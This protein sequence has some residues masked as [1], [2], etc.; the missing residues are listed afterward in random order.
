MSRQFQLD[1]AIQSLIDV[2]DQAESEEQRHQAIE[3]LSR[4]DSTDAVRTLMDAYRSS[5]W[6][7]TKIQIL[8]SM[9][10][11]KNQRA[12]EFL[13]DVADRTEDLPMAS[14]ALLALGEQ[15]S[16]LSAIYLYQVLRD[17]RHPLQKE[18]VIAL[19]KIP[20]FDCDDAL[21]NCLRCAQNFAPTTLQ[22]VI[23][24]CARRRI[25]G[26]LELI[27]SI[28]SSS[29]WESSGPVFNAVIIAVGQLG[30]RADVEFLRALNTRYRFFADQLVQ[31]SIQQLED[32]AGLSIEDSVTLMLAADVPE[33][34]NDYVVSLRLHRLDQILQV[35]K[36]LGS[37]MSSNVLL[38]V[39]ATHMADPAARRIILDQIEVI[40]T[41]TEDLAL[42]LWNFE[43]KASQQEIDQLIAVAASKDWYCDLLKLV[44]VKG[45]HS[46]LIES[47][48]DEKRTPAA[49]IS[50]CN[51]LVSQARLSGEADRNQIAGQMM[52]A[53]R[54]ISHPQVKH[55][56]I[57][58]I[59]QI[60]PTVPSLV[61]DL[62]GFLKDDPEAFG[63]V[64]YSL[65]ALN[66]ADAVKAISKRL[67]QLVADGR[68]GA[69][70]SACLRSLSESNQHC[71]DLSLPLVKSD[72][73]RLHARGW[74]RI[75]TRYRL[76]GFE[77]LIKDALESTHIQMRLMG[78][79]AASTN[80]SV[81][82]IDEIFP[83]TGHSSRVLAGRALHTICVGGTPAQQTRVLNQELGA[84]DF[85][86]TRVQR[87]LRMLNV[88]SEQDYS[89]MRHVLDGWLQNQDASQSRDLVAAV[90]NFRDNLQMQGISAEVKA[91]S[92]TKIPDRHEIDARLIA[93]LSRFGEVSETIKSVL[94]NAELTFSHPELFDDR[95]DKSTMIVEF[96]KS[97]DLYLQEKLGPPIFLN[98]S[99]EAFTR[100]QSR[101][102]HLQL[103][104]ESI[105]VAKRIKDLQIVGHFDIDNFPSHKLVGIGR[106]IGS[107][108]ILRDQ[109]K[110]IDGL[111]AWALI[112]L[113]F[114]R[115]FNYQGQ[116]LPA[117]LPVKDSRNRN[118]GE[119]ASI[120]NRLQEIRNLAAHRG[121][122][123]EQKSLTQ[124]REDSLNV[125]KR[126]IDSV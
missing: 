12:Q 10:S 68:N 103:E 126:L 47:I 40:S 63:S 28:G 60:R 87:I 74:L 105:S 13:F 41:V 121:T 62:V 38:R 50:R 17:D 99:R 37:E 48:C 91:H 123:L 84:A 120:L 108:K 15:Q 61:P 98:P 115:E 67:R 35:A 122:M 81:A 94:R 117:L 22:F 82:L 36:D 88:H 43:Q 5:T 19:A 100:L 106:L 69:E 31:L 24:A 53:A 72:M 93:A 79:V 119:I 44:P 52:S 46:Q 3:E 55:R 9:G 8:R 116:T 16:V 114:G 1:R 32:R 90:A 30:S 26:A 109:Y 45:A 80:P 78:I 89:S 85:S 97:I 75:L 101:V 2:V 57:R 77:S 18:A 56:L 6:R 66:H 124:V 110:A 34:V 58:A 76:D 73:M 49:R 4:I 51:A 25:P 20:L 54:K 92:K 14:E 42:A 33:A 7:E 96:V 27:R 21:L 95:V 23:L 59:S 11:C 65:S 113:V 83:L 86:A 107:G 102:I 104:D 118:I 112:L 64:Y 125:M 70:V 111:R 71:E 29:V 39:A